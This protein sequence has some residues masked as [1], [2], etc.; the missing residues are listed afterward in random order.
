MGS[1]EGEEGR[2]KDGLFLAKLCPRYNV[3][4]IHHTPCAVCTASVCV[5][6]CLSNMHIKHTHTL[7]LDEQQLQSGVQQGKSTRGFLQE[8]FVL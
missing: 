8:D 7:E 2:K 1:W 4:I 3:K 6:L 5:P